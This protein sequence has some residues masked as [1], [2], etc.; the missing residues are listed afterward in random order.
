MLENKFTTQQI[1]PKEY[2]DELKQII[3]ERIALN[4]CDKVLE[5]L[6][7]GEAYAFKLSEPQIDEDVPHNAVKLSRRLMFNKIVQCKRCRH[8]ENGPVDPMT[9]NRWCS[10]W[11]EWVHPAEYC[12]RAIERHGPLA[13]ATFDCPGR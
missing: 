8:T 13:P 10:T 4:L 2:P 5:I 12:A 9:G 11:G 7:S 6:L 1:V 3:S